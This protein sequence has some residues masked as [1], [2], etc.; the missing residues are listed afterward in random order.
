M[1]VRKTLNASYL[2]ARAR[3]EELRA[4]RAE[5]AAL[6]AAG[7]GNAQLAEK[8]QAARDEQVAS[9]MCHP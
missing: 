6:K 2:L 4:A 7:G 8:L 3:A 9:C 5:V 1:E